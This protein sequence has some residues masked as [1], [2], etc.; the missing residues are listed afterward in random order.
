MHCH[1]WSSNMN[2]LAC[3]FPVFG[4]FTDS[5]RCE[6]LTVALIHFRKY[7]ILLVDCKLRMGDQR[8]FSLGRRACLNTATLLHS[9]GLVVVLVWGRS[10]CLVPK[11]GRQSVI[12]LL[13]C[14]QGFAHVLWV[15]CLQFFVSNVVGVGKLGEVASYLRVADLQR[16]RVGLQVFWRTTEKCDM[17]IRNDESTWMEEEW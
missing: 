5:S 7:C 1:I 8:L 16:G 4:L 3:V 6:T 12:E 10:L 17:L 14:A 9:H 2:S 11:A 15:S 13:H